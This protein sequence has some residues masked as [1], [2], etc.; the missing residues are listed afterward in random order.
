MAAAIQEKMKTVINH[1]DERLKAIVEKMKHHVSS[2]GFLFFVF[3]FSFMGKGRT[4]EK[5][6]RIERGQ[7]KQIEITN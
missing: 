2:V 7:D 4:I 6:K 3:L 1:R 5:G